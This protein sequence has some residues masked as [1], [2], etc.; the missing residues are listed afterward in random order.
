MNILIIDRDLEAIKGIEW[1]LKTYLPS[2]IEI[3]ST[4]YI[5]EAVDMIKDFLPD[6]III[7]TD[8][9][10]TT[11]QQI[12]TEQNIHIIA[13]TAQP[14]FQ[15]ALKA[16]KLQAKHLFVKP[17]PLEELKKILISLNIKKKTNSAPLLVK[18]SGELYLDLYLN[19]STIIDPS[20]KQFFLLE[21]SNSNNNIDLYKWLVKA[22]IFNDMTIFPLQNRILCIVNHTDRSQLM[23]QARSL[24]REWHF[25]S[26]D[27][28]N[29]GIYNGEV[30]TLSSMYEE[31]EKILSQRFYKGYEHIFLSS[32]QINIS[33]LDPLLTPDEQHL[34]ISSLEAADI[35]SIK[36]FLYRLCEPTI[37][38]HHEEVRIHLT[39]IL[40]QIRRF[41]MKYNLQ[42]QGKIETYYR[43]LFHI[44]LE[45]PILY[46][47]IE[48]IILFTQTLM[49]LA[50]EARQQRKTDYS[51]LAIEYIMTH[52][53]DSTLTLQSVAENLNISPNYLSNVFSKKQGIPFKK[54]L[55]QYR[56]K[57]A[58]KSLF[59][60]D[61]AISEIAYM[62]GFEDPNYFIKVFKQQHH[63]TPY[64]YRMLQREN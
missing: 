2:K 32:E 25:M 43:K 20:T 33:R 52:Y 59:E 51:E 1:Y 49:H 16:I 10:N 62:N 9:I 48:E 45:E 55:Q 19:S 46:R 57:E 5:Q 21:T 14:I 11:I 44:I 18:E 7:E 26:S 22:P 63:L 29:I 37:Y 13:L 30:A 27:Y 8:S 42:Q 12:I 58:S 35:S 41:M 4:T 54:F 56:I 6:V 24:I 53:S 31:T 23:K 40:A 64:R 36:K 15:H 39:S 34:W 47:I 17:V 60:T 50:L 28:L 38:Y 3:Q 61:F